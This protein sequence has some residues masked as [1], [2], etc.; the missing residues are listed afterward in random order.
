[1]KR[2]LWLGC[3]L[4][5][6]AVTAGS[7]VAQSNPFVGT[8]KLNLAKSKFEGIPAPT[9]LTRTVVSNE[10]G[11]T[12]TFSGTSADGKTIEY[13]FS[14]NYD[15][16]DSAVTGS[17]MPGGVDTVAMTRV[18]SNMVRTI[19]KKGGTAI[20]VSNTEVSRDGKVS[21]VKGSGVDADGKKFSMVSVYD[22]E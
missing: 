9:I 16:K 14:S 2:V 18:N 7:L 21:I 17:G 11:A 20:G 1:M 22:E 12:Y 3:I 4:A 6:S 19:W 10:A 8:W 15:G 5:L 13:S